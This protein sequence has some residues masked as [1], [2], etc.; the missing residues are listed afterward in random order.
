MLDLNGSAL[1][2]PPPQP[3]PQP[4]PDAEYSSD[5]DEDPWFAAWHE[6]YVADAEATDEKR[7][8]TQVAKAKNDDEAGPSCG[9]TDGR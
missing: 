7:A 8:R 6:A 3:E 1:P 4:Q 9:P 5:D 2:P